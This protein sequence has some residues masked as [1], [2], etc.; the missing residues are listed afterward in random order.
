MPIYNAGPLLAAQLCNI[1]KLQYP[2]LQIILVDDGSD[3]GSLAVLEA[4]AQGTMWQPGLGVTLL[5]N[6]VNRGVAHARNLAV[7]AALGEYLWFA[8]WD[9]NWS[10]QIIDK[11]VASAVANNSD[12][13]LCD[14][15]A[16]QG[17]PAKRIP[18][19]PLLDGYAALALLL[20]KQLQ[21]YLW[22]KL[23][24]RQLFTSDVFPLLPK[25]SDEAGFAQLLAKTK[26]ISVVPEQLYYYR[27]NPQS[28]TRTL[29]LS[30]AN[31]IAVRQQ[32]LGACV[33]NGINADTMFRRWLIHYDVYFWR[34]MLGAVMRR[35]LPRGRHC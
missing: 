22:A 26:R 18:A 19:S 13:V 9:D 10:P 7:R 33:S 23:F 27:D 5:K 32:V 14:Y 31:L 17:Q 28:L 6:P 16:Q 8:D 20:K 2:N 34:Y 12:I 11:M 1:N 35:I 15:I 4:F 3:D 21:S 29:P 24:R 30:P 25:M